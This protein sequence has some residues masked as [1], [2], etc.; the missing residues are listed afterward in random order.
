MPPS[1][2]FSEEFQLLKTLLNFTEQD[3]QAGNFSFKL[4][5]IEPYYLLVIASWIK[6][7]KT[8]RSIYILCQSGLSRDAEA[9]SRTLIEAIVNLLYL[10][11]ADQDDRTRLFGDYLALSNKKMENVLKGSKGLKSIWEK[12]DEESKAQVHQHYIAALER[13]Y[14]IRLNAFQRFLLR[15]K[16]FSRLWPMAKTWSGLSTEQMARDVGLHNFYDLPYRLASDTV[17][18]TDL[19]RHVELIDAEGGDLSKGLHAV[20]DPDDRGTQEVLVTTILGFYL[21]LES[22]YQTLNHAR[23]E[24]LKQTFLDIRARLPKPA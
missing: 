12:V 24:E 3:L 7:F 23:F 15:F 8:S 9:L 17:H 11:K 10:S 20:L 6:T 21:A 18:G 22:I 2:R 16:L 13:R 14:S 5:H 4:H 1:D 19:F